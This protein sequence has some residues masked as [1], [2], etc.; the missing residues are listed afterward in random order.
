MPRVWK[1]IPKVDDCAVLAAVNTAARHYRGSLRLVLT[2]P[3]RGAAKSSAGMKK[4]LFAEQRNVTLAKL[5]KGSLL[6]A[7][8]GFRLNAD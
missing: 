7:D 1:F 2:A 5:K 4:R 6:H 3:A 8:P